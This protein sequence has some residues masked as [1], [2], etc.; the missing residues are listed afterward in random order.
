MMKLA[1]QEKPDDKQEIPEEKPPAETQ[2]P[3]PSE[4]SL[5]PNYKKAMELSGQLAN[6]Y[7]E[8]WFQHLEDPQSSF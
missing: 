1:M 2:K 6:I 7:Q 5:D 3:E 4:Q 8:V